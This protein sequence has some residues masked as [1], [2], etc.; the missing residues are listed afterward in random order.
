MIAATRD[1]TAPARNDYVGSTACARCHADIYQSFSRTRMGRSLVTVSPKVIQDLPIPGAFDSESLDRHYEIFS[2]QGKLFQSES[3]AGANGADVFRDTR[4]IQW[5]IGAGANGY[6]ALLQRDNYLFEAPLS[7]YTKSHTWELSPGYEGSDIGFSRTIQA[8]CISC[9]S[10]RAYPADPNTGRYT[11]TPFSETAIGCEN[12]HGPGAKHLRAVGPGGSL[13]R[14]P[15]IVNPGRLSSELENDICMSCHEAGDTRVLKPG[16]TY[17]D[18]RPGTPLDNTFSILM[19]PLKRGD[20]DDRDHVQHYFEMSMSKCFRA[21]AG[22]LRCAT[23]HDPH[24]EP[25]QSEAPGYF[26]TK[27]V[28]CHSSRACTLPLPA[29]Q[30]TKPADNCIGCH[31]PQREATE[32]AHTSLTNHRILIRPG[33]PWPEEAFQLTSAS[34][35]DL[36]H[37]NRVSGESDEVPQLALLE[38][39]R[40]VSERKPE[41]AASYQRVLSELEQTDPDHAEVQQGVGKRDLDNGDLQ[42]AVIHLRRA[43]QLDPDLGLTQAYLSE[44]LA[45][46]NQLNE[47]IDASEKAVSLDQYNP[48]FRKALIDRLIA[49]KRYDKAIAAME[50]YLDLFPEDSFMRKM[51]DLAKQ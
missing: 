26:N 44:A 3:Q 4:T 18:F 39:Y 24:V 21:S 2:S 45:Q 7:Y 13:A 47:A 41:Y 15:Q 20:A 28:E 42:Q 32:T 23:C 10:G 34:L 9:H 35:S 38:A 5:I 33:E 17:Q 30:Q 29:R 36:V 22:Q 37:L 25:A 40:E 27:C 6:G 1:S 16:K 12:C 11:P 19:V 8:G 14:G 50:L 51:L 46:L 43:I 48:L 31:M 49:A